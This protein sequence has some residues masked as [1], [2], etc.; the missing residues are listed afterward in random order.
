MENGSKWAVGSEN[1]RGKSKQAVDS[2]NG[3]G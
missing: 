1:G 2:L 3:C